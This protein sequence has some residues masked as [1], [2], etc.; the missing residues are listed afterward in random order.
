MY[1]LAFLYCCDFCDIGSLP[2][3]GAVFGE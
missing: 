1:G 3:E 2:G